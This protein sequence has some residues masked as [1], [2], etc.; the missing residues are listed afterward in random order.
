M[1]S[2]AYNSEWFIEKNDDYNECQKMMEWCP[3][4]KSE[5]KCPNLTPKPSCQLNQRVQKMDISKNT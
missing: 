4:N 2:S 5:N 1:V 3:K